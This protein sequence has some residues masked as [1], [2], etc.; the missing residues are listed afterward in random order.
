M[1]DIEKVHYYELNFSFKWST[2]CGFSSLLVYA[3][4]KINN[5]D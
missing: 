4:F 2:Y 3:Y 5:L 1:E